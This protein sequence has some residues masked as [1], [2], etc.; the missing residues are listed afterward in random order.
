MWLVL[1]I[2]LLIFLL[3][4]LYLRVM[5]DKHVKKYRAEM[6]GKVVVLT[7]ASTPLGEALARSFYGVG[8]KMILVGEDRVELERVRMH[9]F[10]LRPKDVPVYQPEVAVI[11]LNQV[12][13]FSAQVADIIEMCGQVDMLINNSTIFTRSDVLSTSIENDIRV[14]NINYFGPI[15]FTKGEECEARN[16]A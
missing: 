15:A 7:G 14:M 10:S 12:N 5:E 1:I 6:P 3:I 13:E 8:A 11:E 9:L 2:L 16:L 4:M